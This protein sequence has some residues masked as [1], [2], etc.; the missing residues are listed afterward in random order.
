[1]WCCRLSQTAGVAWQKAHLANTSLVLSSHC[2]FPQLDQGCKTTDEDVLG[3]VCQP[4]R[5]VYFASEDCYLEA[6][7][8]Y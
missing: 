7:S 2:W 1:M 3:Y 8:V 4:D 5:A 6:D